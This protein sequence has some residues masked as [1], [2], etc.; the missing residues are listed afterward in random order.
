MHRKV[1]EIVDDDRQ[2][3]ANKHKKR[4]TVKGKAICVKQRCQETSTG[5]L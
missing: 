4:V 5:Y 3:P 1:S 2:P